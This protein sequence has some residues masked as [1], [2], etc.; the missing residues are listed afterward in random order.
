ME[1]VL[2]L[3]NHVYIMTKISPHSAILSLKDFDSL[4]RQPIKDT[5]PLVNLLVCVEYL[6]LCQVNFLL[7]ALMDNVYLQMNNTHSKFLL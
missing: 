4:F 1:I 2:P 5:H 3:N 6:M 7:F